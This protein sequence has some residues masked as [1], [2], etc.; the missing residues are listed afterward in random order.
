M[1]AF[2]LG[3]LEWMRYATALGTVVCLLL[4]PVAWVLDTL[5]ASPAT[6]HGSAATGLLILAGVLFVATAALW[7]AQGAFGVM[8][9]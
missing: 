1:T 4:A 2:I 5:W 3:A 6:R 7:F 9:P 8:L